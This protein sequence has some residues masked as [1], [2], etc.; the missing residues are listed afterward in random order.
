MLMLSTTDL[1]STVVPVPIDVLGPVG[2][3]FFASWGRYVVWG[4]TG[5]WRVA[6]VSNLASSALFSDT[7]TSWWMSTVSHLLVGEQGGK[8]AA[9]PLAGG[10]VH[11]YEDVG[12]VIPAAGTKVV[13]LGV[14]SE[15][16]LRVMD[17][18]TGSSVTIAEDAH[19]DAVTSQAGDYVVFTRESRPGIYVSGI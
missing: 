6:P 13:G 1:T 3:T 4:E 5:G 18:A 17:L 10:A 12:K 7:A 16:S 11:R 15:T 9:M 2:P 19:T 8:L 14:D